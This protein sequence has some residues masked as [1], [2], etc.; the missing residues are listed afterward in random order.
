MRGM[1]KD[2]FVSVGGINKGWVTKE[3]SDRVLAG[4]S[5]QVEEVFADKFFH[6]MNLKLR[7]LERGNRARRSKSSH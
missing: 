4:K 2:R 3:E 5:I 6:M 1:K 7:Q